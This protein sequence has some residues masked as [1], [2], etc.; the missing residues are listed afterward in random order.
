MGRS[1][2]S[3]PHPHFAMEGNIQHV[4][5][6]SVSFQ[7]PTSRDLARRYGISPCSFIRTRGYE[8]ELKRFWANNRF[9]RPLNL[10]L[11]RWHDSY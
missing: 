9:G 10:R 5:S 4:G 6:G 8:V 11:I 3:G 1:E 2:M 7:N